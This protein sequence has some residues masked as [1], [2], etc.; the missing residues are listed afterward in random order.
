MAR[1][2]LNW[3]WEQPDLVVGPVRGVREVHAIAVKYTC[4][5]MAW[6]T[7]LAKDLPK[8]KALHEVARCQRC[9]NKQG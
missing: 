1:H 7:G 4:G 5:H 3:G 9:L 2:P 6:V 8:V